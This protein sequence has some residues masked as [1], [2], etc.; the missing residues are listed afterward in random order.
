MFQYFEFQGHLPFGPLIT[1][2][3]SRLEISLDLYRITTPTIYLTAD[4]MLDE[5]AFVI[6]GRMTLTT[7]RRKMT[8]KTTQKK[9]MMRKNQKMTLKL[10]N[11]ILTSRFTGLVAVTVMAILMILLPLQ[12]LLHWRPSLPIFEMSTNLIDWLM[13]F[14][15]I[16]N[17]LLGMFEFCFR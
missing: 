12:T 11:Q 6:R 17:I 16:V 3:I 5:I 2:L 14:F 10:R 7:T 15:K 4:N 1:R 9:I 8:L 13:V